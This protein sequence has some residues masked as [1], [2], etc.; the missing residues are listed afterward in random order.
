M[1]TNN[2][3]FLD[4]RTQ[5]QKMQSK[6]LTFGWNGFVCRSIDW[7][8]NL[9]HMLTGTNRP[10]CSTVFTIVR[11]GWMK[12]EGNEQMIYRTLWS[13][14]KQCPAAGVSQRPCTLN[15]VCVQSERKTRKIVAHLFVRTHSSTCVARF[16]FDLFHRKQFL[17]HAPKNAP[18]RKRVV[19]RTHQTPTLEFKLITFL[20]ALHPHHS[21]YHHFFSMYDCG[22]HQ[23]IRFDQPSTN[24]VAHWTSIFELIGNGVS[25]ALLMI[26]LYHSKSIHFSTAKNISSVWNTYLSRFLVSP[27]SVILLH[28]TK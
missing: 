11:S 17:N 16:R 8:F 12:R 19:L 28:S 24:E 20:C 22:H 1:Q 21:H 27:F 13:W 4:D 23:L 14:S 2:A 3:M 7:L 9:L 26:H 5:T 10:D 18:H 15:D 6:R 25:S